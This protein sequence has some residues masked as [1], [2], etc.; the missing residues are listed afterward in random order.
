MNTLITVLKTKSV[1][2]AIFIAVLSVLQG[3]VFELPLTP[4]HQMIVGV[5]ISVV[6]V[7]LKVIENPTSS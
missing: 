7:L 4:I 3:F 1:Q 2:W 6:V 5:V